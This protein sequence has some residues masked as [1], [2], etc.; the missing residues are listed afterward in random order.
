[1]VASLL[2]LAVLS[3]QVP[4]RV[5]VVVFDEEHLSAGNL[6]RL[7]SAAT[8]LFTQ[9]F[10]PGDLGGVIV[11]GQLAGNRLLS[12]REELLRAVGRA[13]PRVATASDLEASAALPGGARPSERLTEIE[14]LDVARAATERKL[15]IV[16]TLFGNLARVDGSKAVL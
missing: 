7:Q 3:A 11:D 2:A 1:M 12:D 14:G 13:H 15:S 4:A 10:R 8:D 9:Q 16:E 6:K 5:F